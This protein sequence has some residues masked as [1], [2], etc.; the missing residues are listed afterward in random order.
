MAEYKAKKTKSLVARLWVI[1]ITI[2]IIIIAAFSISYYIISNKTQRDSKIR[3]SETI[4]SALSSGIAVNMESYKDISRLI[5]L[6]EVVTDYLRADTVG[7]GITNDCRLAVLDVLIAFRNVD[8]VIIFR[9]DSFY[10]NTGRG[11][12][13]IDFSVMKNGYWLREILDRRG[14]AVVSMNGNG[15]VFRKSG[16]DVISISRAIYDIYT[17]KQVGILIM[18]ISKDMLA[19]VVSGEGYQNACILSENGTYLAGNEDLAKYYNRG[20]LSGDIVHND[21]IIDNQNVMISGCQLEGLPLVLM[22]KTSAGV[23]SVPNELISV[24]LLLLGMFILSVLL[25]GIFIARNITTPLVVLSQGMEKTKESGYIKP[26]DAKIPNNEIGMLLDSYNSVVEYLNETF[27]KLID[28]EKVAQRAQM[29]VLQEQIKPHFLYNSLETISYLS[30][31]AGAVEVQNALETLGSFYRNFLSKGD[32]E[33][34]LRKEINIIKDYLSLQKLRYKDI[35]IDEY[36][37]D[38]NTLDIMIPKLLLQPLVENSIYHG[39]RLKGEEGIIRITSYL[40]DEFLIIKVYDTGVGMSENDIRHIIE[41]KGPQ[42]TDENA[43]KSFGLRGTIERIR[44]Y[45]DNEDAV[46][47]R[48]ELGEYTE[49]EIRIPF[50]KK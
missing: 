42:L 6:D 23:E 2:L 11:L 13:N 10:M 24:L 32:R 22:C 50:N 37:I 45:C 9:N 19:R 39:I 36:C 18:N 47:I 27:D 46:S 7:P 41:D 5:M 30:L 34:P 3:E 44:F 33:I 20:Y 43:N 14:G 4:I 48:S 38:D 28:K 8:S 21:I 12:Y 25:A 17:Q 49:I 1:M 35:I 16:P 40:E 26:I 15:A 31:E 29:R